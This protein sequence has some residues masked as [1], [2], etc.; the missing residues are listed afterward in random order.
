MK[1]FVTLTFILLCPFMMNGQKKQNE[2]SVFFDK[3]VIG[4][5]QMVEIDKSQLEL[6][7]IDEESVASLGLSFAGYIPSESDYKAWGVKPESIR[8]LFYKKDGKDI[9]GNIRIHYSLYLEITKD[10][11]TDKANK[12]NMLI[13]TRDIAKSIIEES[14]ERHPVTK[15]IEITRNM[16]EENYSFLQYHLWMNDTYLAKAEILYS[17]WPLV[18]KYRDMKSFWS[19]GGEF[20]TYISFDAM[21]IEL[22]E[23]LKK[24]EPRALDGDYELL[25]KD[26]ISEY[27]DEDSASK[28]DKLLENA[29]N[30]V[31]EEIPV[32]KTLAYDRIYIPDGLTPV[33]KEEIDMYSWIPVT[34]GDEEMDRFNKEQQ[35]HLDFNFRDDE[36]ESN[37]R[38]EM[39]GST[40]MSSRGFS[41]IDHSFDNSPRFEIHVKGLEVSIVDDSGLYDALDIFDKYLD[42]SNDSYSLF[43]DSGGNLLFLNNDNEKHRAVFSRTKKKEK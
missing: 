15:D 37:S 29:A 12:N 1:K 3:F 43:F 36:S 2:A 10:Y 30:N 9:L 40:W 21:G 33:T 8:L 7:T 5:T 11:D 31:M 39:R 35:F 18:Q 20:L 25:M 6:E 28:L 32:K 26:D 23:I 4:K 22:Q 24:A 38:M 42:I 17:D 34:I 14:Q 13:R 16:G 19:E 27:I 41:V